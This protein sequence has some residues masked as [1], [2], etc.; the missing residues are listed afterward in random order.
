VLSALEMGP[1]V[2]SYN[3]YTKGLITK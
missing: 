1:D 3:K 2:H